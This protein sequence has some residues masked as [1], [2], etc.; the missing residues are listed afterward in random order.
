MPRNYCRC[1]PFR[2]EVIPKGLLK[3]L[4]LKLLSNRP[5]HGFELMEQIFE[6]TDGMWR[7]GPAAIYP[8]LQWLEEKGY[9]KSMEENNGS[10]KSRKPYSITQK[11]IDAV[12]EYD[13]AIKDMHNRMQ[14]FTSIWLRK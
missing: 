11:G 8:A 7:P 3:P 5:M 1:G 14:K 4:I 6:K 9:I 2:I 13:K 10:E 12:S